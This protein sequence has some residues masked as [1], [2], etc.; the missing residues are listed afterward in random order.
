MKVYKSPLDIDILVGGMSERPD[1]DSLLGPT[2]SCLIADQM[3]RTRRG[4]RYFFSNS[5]QPL[6]FS[7]DQLDEIQKVTLARIFC[8]NGDD[9]KTMQP[10]VF[11]KIS[12]K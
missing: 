2:F 9:I 8:D 4:D 5:E 10:S 12:D 6:P 1:G 11:E 3:V 7:K